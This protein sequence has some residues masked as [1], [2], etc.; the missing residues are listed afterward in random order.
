MS[1]SR[2]ALTARACSPE[3]PYDCLKSTSS[4]CGGLLEHGDELPVGLAWRRIRDEAQV[5]IGAALGCGGADAGHRGERDSQ[6]AR[7]LA[8][9]RNMTLVLIRLLL[10]EYLD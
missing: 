4:P 8:A 2:P 1:A 3:A 5:R 10:V 6:K 7:S 9:Q